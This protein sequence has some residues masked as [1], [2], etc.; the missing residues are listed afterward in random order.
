MASVL[1]LGGWLV[2]EEADPDLQPLLCLEHRGLEQVTG[3]SGP[4]LLRTALY[5][6]IVDGW[7]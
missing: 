1:R 4:Q 5:A 2:L 6:G 3:G 7:T